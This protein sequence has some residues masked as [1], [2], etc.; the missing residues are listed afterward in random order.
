MGIIIENAWVQRDTELQRQ[1]ISAISKY[2]NAMELLTV[3]RELS[4][5]DNERFQDYID[6]FF[7]DWIGI[8]GDEG[9]TNYIHMLGSGHIH[10]FMKKYG[11]MYLYSQQGW[12]ALNNTI[13]SSYIK[14]PKKVGLV[15]VRVNK[16]RTSIP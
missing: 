6:D 5:D 1:L 7:E 14:I 10:Y 12:E 9:I 13:Q 8:F 16:N 3:H 15:V 2:R 11:C 4:D